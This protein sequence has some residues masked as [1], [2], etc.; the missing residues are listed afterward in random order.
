MCPVG[1]S[2]LETDKAIGPAAGAARRPVAETTGCC[3]T[4]TCWATPPP[5][6]HVPACGRR[7]TRSTWEASPGSADAGSSSVP[8]LRGVRTGC[9]GISPWTAA[10]WPAIRPEPERDPLRGADRLAGLLLITPPVTRII[11]CDVA[12]RIQRTTETMS[13]TRRAS[14]RRNEGVPRRS[15][16]RCHRSPAATTHARG[17]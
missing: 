8:H 5:A 14:G 4:T 3:C 12:G 17:V 11:H 7:I 9:A 1:R 2:T 15:F 6:D 10:C 16:C 13:S